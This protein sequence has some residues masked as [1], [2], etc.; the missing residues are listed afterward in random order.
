MCFGLE[1]IACIIIKFMLFTEQFFILIQMI[2]KLLIFII[3]I[4]KIIFKLVN[5]IKKLYQ[6]QTL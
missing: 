2:K 5:C 3:I 4:S 1:Y 6:N